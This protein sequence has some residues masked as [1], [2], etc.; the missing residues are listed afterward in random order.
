[1]SGWQVC[2]LMM[3]LLSD[4]LSQAGIAQL[5]SPGVE[6]L[7]WLKPV[8]AEDSLSAQ[9]TVK[10]KQRQAQYGEL[11]C[12]IDVFNQH[13]D[14]VMGLRTPILVAYGEDKL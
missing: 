14:T 3:R 2:A 7:R 5:G 13:G 12:Q 9:I 1:A 11:L 10:D 4:T 6:K 8:Y